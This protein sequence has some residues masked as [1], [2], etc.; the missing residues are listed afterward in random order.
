MT[1]DGRASKSVRHAAPDQ[2]AARNSEKEDIPT[3]VYHSESISVEWYA[4]R[5]THGGRCV[6]ALPQVFNP[7]QRPWIRVDAADSEAVARAVL[8]CPSGALQLV[9][10]DAAAPE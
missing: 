8:G 4:H 1:R 2:H 7:Q 3:R 10:H 5:C 6:R 9:R